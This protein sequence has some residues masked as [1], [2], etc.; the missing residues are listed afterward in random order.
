MVNCYFESWE[1]AAAVD[2]SGGWAS[3]WLAAWGTWDLGAGSIWVDLGRIGATWD[4]LGRGMGSGID[5][6][7]A[8]LEIRSLGSCVASE[9]ARPPATIGEV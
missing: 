5:M 8:R 6:S 2:A 4:D 3:V 9:D 1:N 7:T